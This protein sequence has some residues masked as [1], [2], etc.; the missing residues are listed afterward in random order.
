V[1]VDCD[2]RIVESAPLL[3]LLTEGA[4]E[5]TLAALSRCMERIPERQREAVTMF[6][7]ERRSYAD[8]ADAMPG[9]VKSVKS[10][11][12]NGKRNLRICLEKSG[13][14]L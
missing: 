14:K 5:E 1:R 12:Q 2:D 6:F 9:D 4:D 8:I 10:N 13:L 3:H 11:I 7:I